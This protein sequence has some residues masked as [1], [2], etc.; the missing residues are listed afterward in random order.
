MTM[1]VNAQSDVRIFL[2]AAGSDAYDQLASTTIQ[3]TETII[4]DHDMAEHGY[5]W[6]DTTW[7]EVHQGKDGPYIDTAGVSPLIRAAVKMLPPTSQQTF[8]AGWLSGTVATLENTAMLGFIAVRN[9]YDQPASI[10][11]GRAWQRLHLWATTQRLSMQ[12]I[13]QMPE[14]VDRDRQLNR[15]SEVAAVMDN[16]TGDPSWRPTF[17][18]RVGYPLNDLLPSARR[19]VSEVI[20]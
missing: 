3:A 2:Y 13:N 17:V 18:F 5:A 9:L 7:Q 16:L 4:A 8:D 15:P 12:P 19:P 11:A 1:L 20:L 14:V 6:V 10:R